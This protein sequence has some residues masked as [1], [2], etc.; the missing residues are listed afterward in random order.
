MMIKKQY[1][2]Y[3]APLIV[4]LVFLMDGQL[5]TLMTN[6]SPGP[7]SIS[8]HMVLMVGIFL[9]FHFPLL[10][11]ISIFAVLGFIYDL[12]Y[13]GVL[14]IAITLMPLSVYLIYYFYQNLPFRA[15]TNQVILLVILFVFEFAA[16]LLARLFSLTNLS[17][18]IFVFYDLMPTLVFNAFLLLLLH[19][20]LKSCFG[21]TNKT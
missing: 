4:L 13:L 19:P 1:L 9:S 14:G 12:Y 2:T 11:S 5:S 15:V 6:W 20:L 21:I 18:F 7:I 16:F 3:L 8:S 17:M 10:Y